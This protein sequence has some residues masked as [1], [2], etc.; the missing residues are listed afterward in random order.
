MMATFSGDS[1]SSRFDISQVWLTSTW[2]H[3]SLEKWR[4]M[5]EPESPLITW[6]FPAE[7]TREFQQRPKPEISR[8]LWKTSIPPEPLSTKENVICMWH[9]DL[10]NVRIGL[11]FA[12]IL[13]WLHFNLRFPLQD[14]ARFCALAVVL[15]SMNVILYRGAI[16][17]RSMCKF[18]ES[19][20]RVH[21][22]LFLAQPWRLADPEV[23]F[24]PVVAQKLPWQKHRHVL[25]AL[26]FWGS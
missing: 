12:Q 25:L 1:V 21:I 22:S 14:P 11:F 6:R 8:P 16:S 23:F 2:L 26:V 9:F 15:L 24:Q 7:K 10:S 20:H 4:A 19:A 5:M 13:V 3:L 18:F 17:D